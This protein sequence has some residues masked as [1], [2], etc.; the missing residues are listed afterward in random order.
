M[1]LCPSCDGANEI[2]LYRSIFWRSAGSAQIHQIHQIYF[3][4]F[5]GWNLA[6]ALGAI[7]KM[8]WSTLVIQPFGCHQQSVYIVLWATRTHLGPGDC[9]VI[10]KKAFTKISRNISPEC[11]YMEN[12]EMCKVFYPYL[13]FTKPILEVR[14]PLLFCVCPYYG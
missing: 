6:Q 14:H 5:S 12:W 11:R 4:S 13:F 9:G 10:L 8:R 3:L 7:F 2:Q 1:V